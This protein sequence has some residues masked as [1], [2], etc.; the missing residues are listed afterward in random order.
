MSGDMVKS[1]SD[2][3]VRFWI[4]QGETIHLKASSSFG[5]PVELTE[6]EA[7]EL[8]LALLDAVRQI[9]AQDSN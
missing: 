1:F 4:E 2:G 9:E 3:E 5:D 7:K 8:A 6:A